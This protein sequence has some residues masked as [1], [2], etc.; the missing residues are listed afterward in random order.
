M[1]NWLISYLVCPI[2]GQELQLKNEQI[3][4][5]LEIL[6]G[7]LATKC[8]SYEYDIVDGIPRFVKNHYASGF[9]LQWKTHDLSQI[10]KGLKNHSEQRF[11]GE[12]G[13]KAE[14]INGKLILDGGCGAGRFTDIASK[15]GARV[16][17][18]DLSEAVE[19]T[20]KNLGNRE[21]VSVV[22]ASLFN[23][24]F[25]PASFDFAFTI[26]VIQHTPRPLEALRSVARMVKPNGEVGVS[27]YKKYWYT[28][29]HQKY[30]LRPFFK[31]WSEKKLYSF[32][33][34]YVPK[35]YPI[36]KY[37]SKFHFLGHLQTAYFRLQTEMIY[38]VCRIQKNL[39]GRCWIL[40]IG[41]TL[42]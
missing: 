29:L 36:S 10:D 42:L 6:S 4:E 26:G 5:N 19:A 18:V 41:T 11:W 27:W 35:L 14:K 24:P 7:V 30:I 40:L 17:A 38:Q 2:S 12:T 8:G 21:N 34:W 1:K 20:F 3:D 23:L 32:V 9:A 15:A 25:K 39:N 37:L 22:Q 28:Y 31:N 33:S 16:V 13:L